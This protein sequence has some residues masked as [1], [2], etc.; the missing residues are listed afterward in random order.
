MILTCPLPICMQKFYLFSKYKHSSIL[1]RMQICC[2]GT[3]LHCLLPALYLYFCFLLPT[4][5]AL[6]PE[7]LLLFYFLILFAACILPVFTVT[8]CLK[9]S[10][11]Y[12]PPTAYCLHSTCTIATWCKQP[13]SLP[14]ACQYVPAI[15]CTYYIAACL[16]YFCSLVSVHISHCRLLFAWFLPTLQMNILL[17]PALVPTYYYLLRSYLLLRY[18]YK[19]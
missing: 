16:L 11:T 10:C 5:P 7:F 13:V 6:Y 12:L 14:A 4:M 18:C 3:K 2:L 1:K 15:T 9:C 8:C 17:S 19:T